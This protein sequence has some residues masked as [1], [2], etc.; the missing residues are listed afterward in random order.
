MLHKFFG[1]LV[2]ESRWYVS[3]F[4]RDLLLHWTPL[5]VTILVLTIVVLGGVAFVILPG[6]GLER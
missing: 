6:L 4:D 2:R 1:V 3:Q 5:A